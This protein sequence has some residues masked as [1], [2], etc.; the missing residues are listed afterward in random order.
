MLN[1]LDIEQGLCSE[2]DFDANK[3]KQ[4][5]DKIQEFFTISELRIQN[6]SAD[7]ILDI[8]SVLTSFKE[9]FVSE[10]KW[11][12]LVH[13]C[14]EIIRQDLYASAFESIFIFS[15]ISHVALIV[16][17][18]NEKMPSLESFLLTL[19]N[20]L[21]EN[22]NNYMN[23]V[24]YEEFLKINNFEFIYGLSGTLRYILDFHCNK[25]MDNAAKKILK[26]FVKRSREKVIN[27]HKI[28]GWHYYPLPHE[29]QY[30]PIDTKNG[31]INY[32]ISHG[33]AG[34]LMTMSLAY[35]KGVEV[36]GLKEAIDGLFA[37]Y[38]KSA[39]YFDNI[40]HWPGRITFEQYIGEKEILQ[41]PR[42][43]S[44][45]YGSLGVLRAMYLAAVY[46]SN[47]KNKNFVLQELKKIARIDKDDY[48]LS[49]PS[50]CHGF[51]GTVAVMEE[52]YNDTKS[53]IFLNVAK[54]HM[55]DTIDYILGAD[56]QYYEPKREKRVYL[57][58][59]IEGYTGMF[60]IIKSFVTRGDNSHKKQLLII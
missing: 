4:V 34:P 7:E 54:Q 35:S 49:L 8:L 19:N 18:L 23:T 57:Y 59:Y 14:L 15:G 12:T 3:A 44:W 17:N 2:L 22:L 39:F 30:L 58:N 5:T 28:L 33:M 46:T 38:H 24:D 31:L 55:I 27:E 53:D 11:E 51:A 6:A 60:Q 26:Y 1:L 13:D 45:C 16:K 29:S 50:I 41:L 9:N 42:Q 37:E 56:Y 36:E 21:C 48:M 47:D 32:G 52:M 25:K 20:I 43:M 10:G 40:I